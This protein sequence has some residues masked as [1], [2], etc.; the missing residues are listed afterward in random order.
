MNGAPL[1]VANGF[2]LRLIAPRFYGI[3]NV[4]WLTR[5]EV[6]DSRFL[7]PFMASRYVTVREEPRGGDSVFMRTAVGKSLLKS[8]TAKVTRKD[9]AHRI[10]GAAWGAPVAH[11]EVRIDDGP[12]TRATIDR[13][14]EHEFAWKFWHLDWKG[15]TP[16]E[17]RITSRAVDTS[18]RLQPAPEDWSIAK[19]HT[20]WEANGQITRR[21]RL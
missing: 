5:I 21:I 17:H 13:G 20:Y 15:P 1:P 2:P 7:G 10:Y 11:V 6:R 9:G 14:Q 3:A 18:G 12:W 8:M 16:G 19:K 4:K